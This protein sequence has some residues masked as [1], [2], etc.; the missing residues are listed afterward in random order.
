M[1][2]NVFLGNHMLREKVRLTQAKKEVKLGNLTQEPVKIVRKGKFS[3]FIDDKKITETDNIAELKTHLNVKE[4]SKGNVEFKQKVE[5]KVRTIPSLT[6]AQKAKQQAKFKAERDEK[7]APLVALKK[8][9]DALEDKL[10]G[11][12]TLEK[13]EAWENEYA[14]LSSERLGLRGWTVNTLETMKMRDKLGKRLSGSYEQLMKK[15]LKK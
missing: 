10:E 11:V 2:Y 8:K 1:T 12:D 9:I 13:W 3:I 5:Q 4:L 14:T 7:M 15:R 6:K